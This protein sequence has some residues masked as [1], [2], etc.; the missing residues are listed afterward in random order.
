MGVFSGRGEGTRRGAD[1]PFPTS[2]GASQRCRATIAASAAKGVGEA[3]AK[4]AA[5]E[6]GYNYL[7]STLAKTLL[8]YYTN[9][10]LDPELY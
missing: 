3:A 2:A 8:E 5:K 4:A 7:L 1:A 6:E 10:K 9:N